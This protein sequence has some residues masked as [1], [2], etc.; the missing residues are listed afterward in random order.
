[1]SAFASIEGGSLDEEVIRTALASIARRLGSALARKDSQGSVLELEVEL[2]SGAVLRSKRTFTK[3]IAFARGAVS[4]IKLSFPPRIRE[5]V[6]KVRARLPGLT[7]CSR[8]QNELATTLSVRNKRD[9]GSPL[10]ESVRAAFG[11]NAVRLAS[12][13][14]LPRRTQ[15][16]R[17]WREATGWR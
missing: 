16:M 13:L 9:S 6:I 17:A 11:E 3:R 15:L 1:V 2:E 4:A 5:P 7:K 8:E 14:T 12:E 10:F